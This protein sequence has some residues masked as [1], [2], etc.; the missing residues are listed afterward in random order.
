MNPLAEVATADL[1]AELFRRSEV[2]MFAVLVG[3]ADAA[4]AVATPP[5]LAPCWVAVH[6]HDGKR[7]RLAQCVRS[8]LPIL[9]G[10]R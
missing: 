6:A 10:V 5:G 8:A 1:I 7:A 4:Q 9:W 3:N 2:G